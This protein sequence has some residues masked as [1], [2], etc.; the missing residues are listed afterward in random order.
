MVIGDYFQ[1]IQISVLNE[2]VFALLLIGFFLWLIERVNSHTA[3]LATYHEGKSKFNNKG[4]NFFL[5]CFLV[6]VSYLNLSMPVFFSI[7]I[8]IILMPTPD[9]LT[10]DEA[11]LYYDAVIFYTFVGTL[12]FLFIMRFLTNPTR[13]NYLILLKFRRVRLDNKLFEDIRIFKERILSFFFSYICIT[14]IIAIFYFIVCLRASQS[15]GGFE[16]KIVR[17]I[18]IIDQTTLIVYTIAF[19][20]ALI[21][22]TIVIEMVLWMDHPIIK[23]PLEKKEN[24]ETL[25]VENFETFRLSQK[26]LLLYHFNHRLVIPII[27]VPPKFYSL[28]KL[29]LDNYIR[30]NRRP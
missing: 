9:N 3:K 15:L 14:L 17:F 6:F 22:F 18:P 19:F 1:S 21:L 25:T 29:K 26:D 11:K 23:L 20:T 5:K 7:Y 27:T 16:S 10:L 13:E 4:E 30:W 8:S 28:L 24:Q 2:V 12:V